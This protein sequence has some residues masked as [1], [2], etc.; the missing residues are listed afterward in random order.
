MAFPFVDIP[1]CIPREELEDS[2]KERIE[3][4]NLALSKSPAVSH[5][6]VAPVSANGECFV[7]SV[8]VQM[9]QEDFVGGL[10]YYLRVPA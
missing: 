6:G 10:S 9:Q 4:G 8:A 5:F 1:G 2:R 3:C 7:R